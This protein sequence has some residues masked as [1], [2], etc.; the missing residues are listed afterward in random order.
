LY[1]EPVRRGGWRAVAKR[2]FDIVVSA[3]ALFFFA[4]LMALIAIAVK[5]DSKGSVFF[6]QRRVGR[7]AT[8]FTIYILDPAGDGVA[9]RRSW[10]ER[11]E[12]ED[13]ERALEEVSG[14]LARHVIPWA[15]LGEE[16]GGV[17]P[18]SRLGKGGGGN[19]GYKRASRL[20]NLFGSW[21]GWPSGLRRTPGKCV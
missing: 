12:D 8:L 20:A 19:D 11:L 16:C 17:R 18:L 6:R 13:P 3:T 7:N 1:L 2:M 21:D 4:P 10:D 9:V 5:L 15:R 14:V